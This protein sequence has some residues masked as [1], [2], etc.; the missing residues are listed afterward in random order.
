MHGQCDV[1]C[2]HPLLV[3]PGACPCGT[4]VGEIVSALHKV[5]FQSPPLGVGK[6]GKERRGKRR[7]KGK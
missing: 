1:R 6:K 4:E 7:R 3:S 5:M 2:S